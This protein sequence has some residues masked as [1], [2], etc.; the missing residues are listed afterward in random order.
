M[1]ILI[2]MLEYLKQKT[3]GKTI[4]MFIFLSPLIKEFPL[5]NQVM[6]V[7]HANTGYTDFRKNIIY[8]WRYEEFEKVIFHEIVHYF[9]ID[10][11]DQHVDKIINISNKDTHSYWEAWTDFL[12]IF[13]HIIYVSLV[14]EIKIK[15]LLE[16]ELTFIRNQA[17]IL[18]DHYKIDDIKNDL[19]KQETPAFSYYI[20]KYLLFEH[21]LTHDIPETINYNK[22]LTKIN[23]NINT[24]NYTSIKIKSS[25]MTLFQLN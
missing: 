11:S 18:I 12:G 3:R 1:K 10:M 22:L 16:Y 17:M 25:R 4:N 15:Q 20:L 23:Y 8:I 21:F 7:E 6:D 19:I 9:E 24:D 14:S 5:R 13:Y 2:Y